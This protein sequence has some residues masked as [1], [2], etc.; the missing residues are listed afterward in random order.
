VSKIRHKAIKSFQVG[1]DASHKE[2]FTTLG[3]TTR[4]E[5][6]DGTHQVKEIRSP[7]HVLNYTRFDSSV[8]VF[9]A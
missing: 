1:V 6:N 9:L 2:I 3:K 8:I 5:N 4:L 7:I